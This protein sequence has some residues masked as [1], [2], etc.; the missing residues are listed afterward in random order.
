[1]A[2]SEEQKNRVKR[3][4]SELYSQV[5]DTGYDMGACWSKDE[6]GNI[7]GSVDI[8]CMKKGGKAIGQEVK[9]LWGK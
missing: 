8:S 9:N 5:N 1:M 6:E 4:M 7:S 3:T 2:L